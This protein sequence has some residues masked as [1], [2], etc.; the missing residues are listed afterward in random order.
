M[1]IKKILLYIL[2]FELLSLV[3]Y[4]YPAIN[5]FVF[6]II[7]LGIIALSLKKIEYGLYLI[8]AELLISS[9]GYLFFFE[10]EGLKI[11]VRISLWL[12]VMSIW[13]AKT[14]LEYF[15]TKKVNITFLKSKF[16]YYF[17]TLFLFIIWGLI[18]G[19][20]QKNELSNVFFDFNG[21]LY[22]LLIFPA[23]DLI[24]G[25]TSIKDIINIFIACMSWL[26][27]ETLFLLYFFSHN[28][29][30]LSNEVYRWIRT[31]G[32]GEITQMSG[33]FSRIFFQS[34]L[35]ILLA[36]FIFIIALVKF[37][38]TTNGKSAFSNKQF[39]SLFLTGC[40]LFST[41]IITLSRSF[42]VG[43]ATG[44][45]VMLV[46]LLIKTKLSVFNF[47]SLVSLIC[48]SVLT[49]GV[50]IIGII[51]LPW[52]TPITEISAT[53][54]ITQRMTQITG[55]AGASSRWLL[56]PELWKGIKTSPIIGQGFGKTITYTSQDPRV[57][58][59]S[60]SGQYTTHAFEWGWLD[61]W[62]KL[63]IFGLIAYLVLLTKIIIYSFKK[64][65]DS[66]SLIIIV[67]LVCLLAL[68]M[69]SPYTNHPLGIG[70]IIFLAILAE[71]SSYQQ[72]A[73][74]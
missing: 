73:L 38:K 26:V 55:E 6:L 29:Y 13:L 27:F 1:S 28:F 70:L 3:I 35:F 57:L 62:L 5:N 53:S 50:I 10:Y 71:N 54:A 67:S 65:L 46:L 34:H 7:I 41:I 14:L 37:L 24:K 56:L 52:P 8:V 74:A 19:L 59:S 49:S 20:L 18:N 22:F 2:F 60:I 58:E 21:W 30:F 11:S 32:V 72:K 63:G 45:A 12:I 40:L 66:T 36:I 39:I 51:K 69:F 9:K 64:T 68:N 17:S 15:K 4:F 23:Y 43:L 31:T 25:K 16:F 42:W 61:A 47:I 33:G 48:L 44:I